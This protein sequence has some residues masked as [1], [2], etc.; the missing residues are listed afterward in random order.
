[1]TYLIQLANLEGRTVLVA[2]GGPVAAQKIEPLAAAGA[3][4][5]VVAPTLGEEVLALA[6]SLAIVDRRPFEERDLDG[7]ALAIAATNDPAVN[8]D[9]A[10]LARA[11]G[12]PVNAVDDPEASTFYVPALVRRGAVT[13]AI[14]TGGG[15]PLF[16]AQLRRVLAAAVPRSVASLAELFVS[17]R[18]R[19]LRG[20]GVRSKLLRALADPAIGRL[21]DR[22]D[23]EA[24]QRRLESIVTEE[25]E[26]FAPGT[27]VIA[28]AGPGARAL[29][30]LRALDR[31]QRADVILHDA[32]VEPEI[33]ELALP[34]TRRVD[35][36]R[37]AN[38]SRAVDPA[39]AIGLML[40][41]A[42]AGAR[43]V[44]LHAGDPLVFGRTAEELAALREA[45]IP[46]ELVPGISS[47]L[48]APAAAGIPLTQRG[49]AR[50]FSV[51]AGHSPSGWQARA[52]DTEEET[53][54]ILMGLG[55]A[56]ELLA[57]LI[58]EGRPPDTPAIAVSRASRAGERVV[59]A[60]LS[61]LAAALEAEALESPATLIVGRVAASARARSPLTGASAAA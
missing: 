57:G 12:I 49:V 59:A 2:G 54:V 6:A 5:H 58:A 15:S 37:R 21:L 29:L 50:A 30:T 16:S 45:E 38:D 46:T 32:L 7:I 22:D 26:P 47:V 27:V 55:G 1:M 3:R 28:G 41:E 19:G 25:E 44:R 34:G 23:T 14:G 60:T 11:R 33:L 31:I 10:A 9:I 53:L 40:R 17:L 39:V 36:G 51:R 52:P 56:R 42:R 24:A 20:L 4:V 61:T 43:V 18:S 35:V 48:A 13:I 8:K